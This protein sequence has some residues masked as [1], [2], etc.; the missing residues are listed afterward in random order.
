MIFTL[1]FAYARRLLI[2]CLIQFETLF[3]WKHHSSILTSLMTI[4]GHLEKLVDWNFGKM[5]F[6]I[7][8]RPKT[9]EFSD[10]QNFGVPFS[11]QPY[12]VFVEFEARVKRFSCL[13]DFCL[14]I[15]GSIRV[16]NWRYRWS[17]IIPT[18]LK[19]FCDMNYVSPES[20][21]SK[22]TTAHVDAPISGIWVA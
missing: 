5:I 19:S 15:H 9:K 17:N 22:S 2:G 18:F 21:D 7:M 4:F 10:K 1:F 6:R 3:V 13:W 14:S 8:D 12:K 11:F 20:V 16:L